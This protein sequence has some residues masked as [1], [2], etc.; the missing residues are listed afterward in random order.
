MRRTADPRIVAPADACEIGG[1]LPEN[2]I[3]GPNPAPVFT[4][5]DRLVSGT[6]L[7]P[8]MRIALSSEPWVA[9]RPLFHLFGT[10]VI[11]RAT[12]KGRA[13]VSIQ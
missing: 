1:E 10:R 6:A 7:R 4:P 2:G 11:I 12:P 13:S 3:R 8:V 5:G 9:A